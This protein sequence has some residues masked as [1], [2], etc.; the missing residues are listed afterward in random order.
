MIIEPT[1][2]IESTNPAMRLSSEFDEPL[3]GI[4]GYVTLKRYENGVLVGQEGHNQVVYIGRHRLAHI[5]CGDTVTAGETV[6]NVLRVAG[7]AVAA[8]GD[9]LNPKAPSATDPALFETDAAK[10]KTYTLATPTFNAVSATTAPTATFTKTITS[11]DA[12]LL[13][14]EAVIAFGSTGPVFAHYTFP[15]MDLRNTTN[16]S[17]EITWQFNF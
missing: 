15:T 12:N 4:Q 10:I 6:L 16:N 3:I 11:A 8:G 13:I 14:N 2:N 5:I 1:T 7:G 9:H 17:L